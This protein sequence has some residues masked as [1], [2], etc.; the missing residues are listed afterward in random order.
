MKQC[1]VKQFNY[2]A[3]I[4]AINNG[5]GNFIVQKLP[6]IVQ[7][8]SVN[9]ISTVDIN[10]DGFADLVLAGNRYDFLPQFERQ[11]ASFGNVLINNK[12]GGFTLMEPAQSGLQIKG[13]VKD[14][15][16]F[17]NANNNYLL[18]LRNDDY[19]ALFQIKK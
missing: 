9:A 7:L 10:N 12:K 6:A 8:S 16:Q 17:K 5:D 18:F 1:Q 4:V 11:D 19:P 14:I 13:E 2:A 15:E 3:S